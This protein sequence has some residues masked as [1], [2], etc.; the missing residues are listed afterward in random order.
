MSRIAR[1]GLVLSCLAA[2]AAGCDGGPWA[3][4][5]SGGIPPTPP[6][7]P[8]GAEA[9]EP[10]R[11][12]K[13][14]FMEM[15]AFDN[16]P[17]YGNWVESDGWYI[18]RHSHASGGAFVVAH[19]PGAVMYKTLE[20]PLAPGVYDVLLRTCLTRSHG[21]RNVVR[22]SLGNRKDGRFVP[23]ATETFVQDWT[24]SRYSWHKVG[25]RFAP[26]KR[27]TT[28]QKTPDQFKLARPARVLRVEA[29][30]VE[31]M[32]IGDDPEYPQ[33]YVILDS[34]MITGQPYE[35]VQD[36]RNSVALRFPEGQDPREEAARMPTP[37]LAAPLDFS[38]LPA[39]KAFV[40]KKNLLRNS[41]FE[42]GLKPHYGYYGPMINGNNLDANCLCTDEPYHGRY[43]V[44]LVPHVQN[45]LD[46]YTGSEKELRYGGGF[47]TTA[48]HR[49]LGEELDTLR[50]DGPLV[51]SAYVRTN[52]REVRFALGGTS[53][54][55][56]TKQWKRFSGPL[57]KDLGRGALFTFSAEPEARVYVDAIQI[58]RGEQPTAYTPLEGLEVGFQVPRRC[59]VCYRQAKTLP[60]ELVACQAGGAAQEL[61]V[62]YTL[63]SPLLQV[64]ERGAARITTKPDGTAVQAVLLPARLG[65]YLLVYE[66]DGHPEQTYAVPIGVVD[67]P[68]TV[69]RT[70]MCGAI[71]STNEEIMQI[72]H[73]AGFDWVNS[74]NDR[75]VY[76]RNV[77]PAPDEMHFY[78]RWWKMWQDKYDIQY[79]L[80]CV[81]FRPPQWDQTIRGTEAAAHM[82][83]PNMSYEAWAEYWDRIVAHTP[84]LDVYIP[85]DELTYHRGPGEAL[86]YV[87]I[88]GRMIRKHD[89]DA[90]VAYSTQATGV[91]EMLERKGDLDLGAA[92]G[93]SRHNHERN[94]YYYDRHVKNL[95]GKQ[96]WVLGV[97]WPTG[98][99]WYS[100]VNFETMEP[101]E[102]HDAR[103]WA[104]RWAE[105]LQAVRN[106]L[107]Y[108]AAVVGVRRWGFYTAKFDSGHDPYSAFPWDNSLKPYVIGYVNLVNF[109]RT[110]ERGDLLHF[111][112][113]YGVAAAW[114]KRNGKTCVMIAPSGGF[115][116]VV[117]HLGALPADK[118]QLYDE[119]LNPM[120]MPDGGRLE[121]PLGACVFVEDAGMG[122]EELLA[123]VRG[124][125]AHPAGLQR[126]LVLP[127][128]EGLELA[129]FQVDGGTLK[130]TDAV[131]LPA[132]AGREFPIDQSRAGRAGAWASV[133]P[134]VPAGTVKVD[135]RLDEPAWRTSAPSFVYCWA[136]LDGSYGALQGIRGFGD[137]LSLQDISSTH[138]VLWDG[139]TIYFAFELLDDKPQ[140]GDTIQIR[141]DADLLGDLA[142]AEVNEDDYTLIV[143]P[144]GKA[145]LW[146]GADTMM[147]NAAVV[148]TTR[149]RGRRYIEVA[150]PAR[151]LGITDGKPRSLG[152]NV[153]LRD[154]DGKDTTVLSWTGNYAPRKS[155][156]GWGQLV[157][158]GP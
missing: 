11:L 88:A 64:V 35:L 13:P 42:L 153:E 55:T 115:E 53:F 127:A 28:W 99:G 74:L 65:A 62:R 84:Y 30:Q 15:S 57:P 26:A 85:V 9:G 78:D 32:G 83:R 46:D 86:R 81:P 96:Y 148:K 126:R 133:A 98:Q 48:L 105:K 56:Q 149:G 50:K 4:D 143:Q 41:S 21:T 101:R 1:Y 90:T 19:E 27:G 69:P 76:P 52:G 94:S 92:L 119:Q 23:E 125:E 2:L 6:Q 33:P 128:G 122:G 66:V 150:L 38:V 89:P 34:L 147:D 109:L 112:R 131:A 17:Y 121:L 87:D 7:I 40:S 60:L 59:H 14:L 73:H 91:L 136:A 116:S 106:S 151:H 72:F 39:S 51:V 107:F 12:D 10:V 54:T 58:E 113:A 31:N 132:G 152:F 108:Q 29:V 36:R 120:A 95:T 124:M 118:V 5:G 111:D 61:T 20:A 75:L 8:A 82:G 154:A 137:V 18:K 139:E 77:W 100:A 144:G 158:T 45:L 102:Y 104:L 103:W 67:D 63:L 79:G 24:G 156:R 140:R 129:T 70:R 22:V 114:L 97:G 37:D 134:K 16:L 68:K 157:L 141:L 25:A 145:A 135:G 130:K 155:P 138:R 146:R 123:A 47:H 110:H 43:C 49:W 3:G 142:D 71:V 117:L 44:E 80:W 93:G